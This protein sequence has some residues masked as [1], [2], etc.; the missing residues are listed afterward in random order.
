MSN[1]GIVMVIE[2]ANKMLWNCH[3]GSSLV[4]VANGTMKSKGKGR[5]AIEKEK[6]EKGCNEIHLLS[7]YLF[8]YSWDLNEQLWVQ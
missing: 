6:E 4:V 7:R 8:L 3:G 1:I 2:A 5:E